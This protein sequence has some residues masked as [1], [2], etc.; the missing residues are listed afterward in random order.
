M[1]NVLR[2]P[3]LVCCLLGAAWMG[4][5]A[6]Q[7]GMPAM[8]PRQVEKFIHAVRFDDDIALAG[9]LDGATGAAAVDPN[10]VDPLGGE[11]AL[12]LAVREGS[13]RAFELLLAHPALDLE[14]RAPN[15]NSAL[16]MAAFRR[17]KAAVLALLARG[18]RVNHPGWSALHYAAAGGDE[19]VVRAL[20]AHRAAIDARAPGKLTPL[21]IAAREG[22]EAAARVLLEEGADASL[23]SAESVDAAQIAERADKP[24]IVAAIAAS[25]A[26]R[27]K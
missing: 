9:L 24:R 18:A 25:L 3:L 21:M 15:G 13:V 14:R 12:V 10:V 6:A 7:A 2:K 8:T 1:L 17:D 23:R 11:P 4:A 16:M 19:Q 26:A 22:H 20:L 27:R 5:G